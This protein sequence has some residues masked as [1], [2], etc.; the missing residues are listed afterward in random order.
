MHALIELVYYVIFKS[1]KFINVQFYCY[2]LKWNSGPMVYGTAFCPVENSELLSSLGCADS[3]T[4]TEEK[5]EAIFQNICKSCDD[6]GWAIEVISPN[7]ICN[8]MLSRSKYSLNRVST[9]SAVGLIKAAVQANVNI[10][11]VYVDT[12]GPPEKY[13]E[14]LKG[15]FPEFDITVAKKADSTYPI[16]S[17][18]SICAKVARDH[19][20]A[21]WKFEEAID[22]AS[23]QFGS[24]Y[25]GGTYCGWRKKLIIFTTA[26]IA[27]F[28]TD[29]A[30]KKFL[31]EHRDPVFGY[32]Q[33]VR[34]SW[35]TVE[36]ALDGEAYHVEFENV[37]DEK[38]VP[39]NVTPI[40]EF[41]K[42]KQPKSASK[43]RHEFF[44]RR[45]IKI[46]TS[47]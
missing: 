36:T 25:P 32:P 34:F 15:L 6:M 42:L 23:N 16:V 38:K 46:C 5:R 9:D 37:E 8:S 18:A 33:L 47:L 1:S 19:A 35:S 39:I 14:Y 26:M 44:A 20:L 22:V 13:E 31:K 27:L 30:T 29:P 4:L 17:A 12:V 45:N 43:Q 2:D 21:V 41:F 11:H 40:T 10:K 7:S 28:C 24:G 3:K